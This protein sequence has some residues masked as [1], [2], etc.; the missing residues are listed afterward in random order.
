M[1]QLLKIPP[2]LKRFTTLP[3]E[4]LMSGIYRGYETNVTMNIQNVLLWLNC[5]SMASSV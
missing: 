1:K 5:R 4:K 2:H 3:C